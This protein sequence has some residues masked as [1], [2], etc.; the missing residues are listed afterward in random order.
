MHLQ[1]EEVWHDYGL[2]L[3]H[4]GRHMEAWTQAC[5]IEPHFGASGCWGVVLLMVDFSVYMHIYIYIYTYRYTQ[6]IYSAF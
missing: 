5:A 3:W 4:V 1:K 2:V 6:C